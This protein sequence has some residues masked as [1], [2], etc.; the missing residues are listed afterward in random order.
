[1]PPLTKPGPIRTAQTPL[2]RVREASAPG[3]LRE[4]LGVPILYLQGLGA[5]PALS[6]SDGVFRLWARPDQGVVWGAMG[7][8]TPSQIY[9][10]TGGG[11][12]G[13]TVHSLLSGLG[14][15]ADDHT[16]Y[17]D[18]TGRGTLQTALGGV[19]SGSLI[20]QGSGGSSVLG[21]LTLNTVGTTS[22][23]HAAFNVGATGDA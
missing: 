17:L 4:G 13:V 23:Q 8:Q 11:G 9:P 3:V 1:M 22:S 6:S 5:D 14:P 21:T 2:E 19:S 15:P 20:L 7:T 16:Q 18:L 12:G 10:P